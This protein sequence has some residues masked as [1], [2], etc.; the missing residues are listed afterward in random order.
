MVN[1]ESNSPVC[2]EQMWFDWFAST[3][4]WKPEKYKQQY[5]DFLGMEPHKQRV[6]YSC[7]T[8]FTSAYT[9]TLRNFD[10]DQWF[11]NTK[12]WPLS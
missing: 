12:I 1:M 4:F 9:E 10:C 6:K 2:A 3:C 11:L 7:A 8:I 5:P